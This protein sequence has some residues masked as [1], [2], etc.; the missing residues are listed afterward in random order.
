MNGFNKENPAPI[1]K[2]DELDQKDCDCVFVIQEFTNKKTKNVKYMWS[3][4]DGDLKAQ[5]VYL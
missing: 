4:V 1:R 5:M 3:R 2:T